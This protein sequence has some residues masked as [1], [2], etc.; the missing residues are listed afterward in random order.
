M[1][2]HTELSPD[3]QT[4]LDSLGALP[5]LQPAR[6]LE[7]RFRERAETERTVGPMPRKW[8]TWGLAAAVVLAVG[9]G[10]WVDR[11]HESRQIAALQR[12][13]A[14]M[15]VTARY[16]WISTTT[17]SSVGNARIV[18]ALT[19][20]LLTDS[21]TNVRVAA[22]L[23]LGRIASPT[24]L[25]DAAE[26]SIRVDPSPFVQ[27]ALL[28]VIHRLPATDRAGLIRA[29]LKRPELDAVIRAEAEQRVKS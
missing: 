5:P 27:A 4:L 12:K 15:S 18:A 9:A 24:L 21:S 2:D 11:A 10:W 14:A 26:Q 13:L 1:I 7:A 29:L 22:A 8:V 16:E 19:T 6:D 28:D 20:S 3:Q 25:R 17:D 23:A